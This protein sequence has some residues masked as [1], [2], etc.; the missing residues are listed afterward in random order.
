MQ[1]LQ[2]G[3]KTLDEL[4]QSATLFEVASGADPTGNAEIL[5]A[6]TSMQLQL[7]Q[8]NGPSASPVRSTLGNRKVSFNLSLE[9]YPQSGDE[10]VCTTHSSSNTSPSHE[11]S[12][13]QPL[14]SALPY[15]SRPP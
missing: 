7:E 8:L 9:S 10:A 15:R 1:V 14:R 5:K 2:K 12:D 3:V 13:D 11:F 6:L 4:L